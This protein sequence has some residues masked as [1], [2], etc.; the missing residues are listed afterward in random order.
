MLQ[1]LRILRTHDSMKVESSPLWRSFFSVH[2]ETILKHN[3]GRRTQRGSEQ[4]EH[5]WQGQPAFPESL[6]F[7]SYVPPALLKWAQEK[8]RNGKNEENPRKY[9]VSLYYVSSCG[10][11]RDKLCER[12]LWIPKIWN[13]ILNTRRNLSYSGPQM[14]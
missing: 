5:H 11:F 8:R 10:V 14:G 4:R 3:R 2:R 9:R 1:I 7:R 6:S 13:F 12:C